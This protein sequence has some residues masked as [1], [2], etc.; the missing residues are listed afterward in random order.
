MVANRRD[1]WWDRDRRGLVEREMVFVGMVPCINLEASD[2][3]T[4]CLFTEV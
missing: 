4:A 1:T 2:L 3:W